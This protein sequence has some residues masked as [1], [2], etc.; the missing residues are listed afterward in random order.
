MISLSHFSHRNELRITIQ[1]RERDY[2]T[3]SNESYGIIDA[4]CDS[5]DISRSIQNAIKQHEAEM[6]NANNETESSI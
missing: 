1:D 4:T 3:I 5:L 2:K 6:A